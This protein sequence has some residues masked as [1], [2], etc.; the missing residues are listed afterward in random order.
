MMNDEPTTDEIEALETELATADQL[1]AG[2]EIVVPESKT[3][4]GDVE[5]HTVE[6]VTKARRWHIDLVDGKSVPCTPDGELKYDELRRVVAD[7]TSTDGGAD[8]E[9]IAGELVIGSVTD[10]ES[11][12]AT[13]TVWGTI[14]RSDFHDDGRRVVRAVG[15]MHIDG[16]DVPITFQS[17][18]AR[19]TI[20]DRSALPAHVRPDEEWRQAG[21]EAADDAR[22]TVSEVRDRAAERRD[23]ENAA[24][25]DRLD[26]EVSAGEST[27]RGGR[28]EGS[29]IR[30]E[31]EIETADGRTLRVTW[32]NVF[33]AGHATHL[34]GDD[35]SAFEDAEIDALAGLADE[36]SPITGRVR[37]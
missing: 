10:S 7:D 29:E 1:S 18:A 14:V 12:P 34:D 3:R 35:L 5:R 32:R 19:A 26:P 8:G 28:G 20:D 21:F 9:E 22:E 2:D 13:A 30:A 15:T 37:M 33:D 31:G 16:E 25:L 17:G 4:S 27:R 24:T 36:E 11:H 6:A 23:A